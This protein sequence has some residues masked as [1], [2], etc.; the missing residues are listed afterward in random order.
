MDKFNEKGL[1]I[2]RILIGFLL[3]Y[4]GYEVFNAKL[5][6]EYAQWEM[7]KNLPYG[8]FLV[9]CGKGLELICGLLFIIGYKIKIAALLTA[10]NM[11]AIMIFVGHGK[12]WYEDQHPFLFVLIAL[13]FYF[14]GAG[15]WS[16]D[17]KK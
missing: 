11:M 16:I 15:I 13:I 10:I 8:L 3:L 2:I 6:K 9:Y 4:H 14:K 1:A 5:M 7:F 12:F 17:N